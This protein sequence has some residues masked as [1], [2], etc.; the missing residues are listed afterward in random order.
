MKVLWFLDR[1]GLPGSY[2]RIWAQMLRRADMTPRDFE[3]FS[4][5]HILKR[6]LLT[7]HGTRKAPT[8]IP[9]E[10]PSIIRAIDNLIAKHKP[11]AVVLTSPESLACLGLH[12]DHATLHNLRGSVYWRSGVPHIVMLPMSA[13]LTMV[14][15]KEIGAANY[16]FESQDA[17]NAATGQSRAIQESEPDRLRS[18][19]T[20]TD[21]HERASDSG[22][23]STTGKSAASPATGHRSRQPGSPIDIVIDSYRTDSSGS[24]HHD[25]GS[26]GGTG[27]VGTFPDQTLPPDNDRGGRDGIAGVGNPTLYDADGTGRHADELHGESDADD[28]GLGDDECEPEESTTVLDADGEDD[29]PGS[30]GGEDEAAEGGDESA[31][32]GDVEDHDPDQF[33]YEPVLSPVGRFV[34]TADTDKLKR[35]LDSGELANGPASPIELIWR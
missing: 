19:G 11:Q 8:W 25:A 24:E 26:L 28:G 13:W 18:E 2:H 34:L 16:G 29:V 5:H 23:G 27:G 9:D 17:F 6:T 15:Q 20:G 1:F 3:C 35:I 32:S 12:P 22:G 7:K 31:V 4:L 14:T 10:G 30:E 21:V 33:F